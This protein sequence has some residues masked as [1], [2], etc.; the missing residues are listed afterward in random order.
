MSH[1][2]V[3]S[4]PWSRGDLSPAVVLQTCKWR[5]RP[6]RARG[7]LAARSLGRP[8]APPAA[9]DWGR[10]Q[11]KRSALGI[12]LLLNFSVLLLR[13]AFVGT[14]ARDP[15][16]I[17]RDTPARTACLPKPPALCLPQRIAPNNCQLAVQ[18][19]MS[20]QHVPNERVEN[21]ACVDCP[22]GTTNP[23][24]LLKNTKQVAISYL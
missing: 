23:M 4:C 14:A 20:G 3:D 18:W 16:P 11:G 15:D 1:G 2:S 19:R 24:I 5:A 12:H 9:C 6:K 22:P 8:W 21:H 7:S 17:R 13:R 10:A